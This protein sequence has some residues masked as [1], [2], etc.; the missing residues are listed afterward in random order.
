MLYWLY[1]RFTRE[2]AAISHHRQY[3]PRL[4]ALLL[5]ASGILIGPCLFGLLV[6]TT[7]YLV[8]P[9]RAAVG[10]GITMSWLKFELLAGLYPT[11]LVGWG[12]FLRYL[13]FRRFRVRIIDIDL[14]VMLLGSVL[15]ICFLALLFQR[16][17]S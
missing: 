4:H 15:V 11:A 9:L 3:R 6:A 7:Y 14:I 2:V 8:L 16:H 1:T 10:S 12:V 5:K 17:H 13:V